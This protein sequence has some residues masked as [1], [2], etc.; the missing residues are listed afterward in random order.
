MGVRNPWPTMVYVNVLL[1]K[2]LS[3]KKFEETIVQNFFW[4]KVTHSCR[5]NIFEEKDGVVLW[6]L[7]YQDQKHFTTITLF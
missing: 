1:C 7:Y 3:Y 2:K 5:K 6:C 4:K